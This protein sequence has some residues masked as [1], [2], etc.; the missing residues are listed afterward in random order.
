M[1][2]CTKVALKAAAHLRERL[3]GAV[4]AWLLVGCYLIIYVGTTA[5]EPSQLGWRTGGTFLLSSL[6]VAVELIAGHT[7]GRQALHPDDP[8]RLNVLGAQAWMIYALAVVAD[9]AYPLTIRRGP[10]DRRPGRVATIGL[11]AEALVIRHR[12]PRRT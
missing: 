12:G 6:G 5:Q 1:R 10:C 2:R 11:A 7:T 3:R 8:H 4:V 9:W